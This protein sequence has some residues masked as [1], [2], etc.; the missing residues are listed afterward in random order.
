MV[1]SLF[2]LQEINEQLDELD[3][4]SDDSG[5][6]NDDHVTVDEVREKVASLMEYV[7]RRSALSRS[8]WNVL[9]SLS[10][11]LMVHRP[12]VGEDSELTN[13][14]KL[15]VYA[16]KL[17]LE[18][19][20]ISE[21][22]YLLEGRYGPCQ[23]DR[24]LK[25]MDSV[26]GMILLLQQKL[27]MEMRSMSFESGG[28]VLTSY[29]AV[30][31]EKIAIHSQIAAGNTDTS[32]SEATRQSV[33][34]KVLASE[35][36]SRAQLDSH[37]IHC[38]QKTLGDL[39]SVSSHIITRTLIQGELTYALHNIKQKVAS[40]ET[41]DDSGAYKDFLFKQLVERQRT[42]C[43][44][45]D[46]YRTRMI[47]S[48]AAIISKEGDEV[49]V[50][51]GAESVL[52]EICS[53]ISSVM[54]RHIQIFKQK[55]RSALDTETA[56]KFDMVVNCLRTDRED[57][58]TGLRTEHAKL[59]SE[60]SDVE[61]IDVPLQSLDTTIENFGQIVSQKAIIRAEVAFVEEIC[62][63]DNSE[64]DFD[65]SDTESQS[66]CETD[67]DKHLNIFVKGLSEALLKEA[68]SKKSIASN[69]QGDDC[70]SLK[71]V[72][73][74]PTL[75]YPPH[76][77]HYSSSIVR[78]AVFQAQLTYMMLK[79]KLQ[80]SQELGSGKPS[81]GQGSKPKTSSDNSRDSE[82][83][84]QSALVPLEEVLDTMYDDECEVLHILDKKLTQL[85]SALRE[86]SAQ[87]W[88]AIEEQ[89]R[90][91]EETFH[92]EMRVV[93]DRHEVH[94]EVFKQE[95]TKVR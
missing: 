41:A 35:A 10:G 69:I 32:E 65:I 27:E 8:D 68:A 52:E 22:A 5:D 76:M 25:E 45:V 29:T 11:Q 75:D 94:M 73:A 93:S 86:H 62:K 57:I 21:M 14:E 28:S 42:I 58:L 53:E 31:A 12:L 89:V 74:T 60:E 85:K 46:E 83:D 84:F 91:F 37:I 44:V 34:A 63:M 24:V 70:D 43:G 2:R 59:G 6:E 26:N 38:H 77:S 72:L 18:S 40:L 78:E 7:K 17:A 81:Y 87:S 55:V 61:D 3:E 1:H 95:V 33:H 16:D 56:H 30:L 90:H 36:L 82:F 4:E 13:D 15:K 51:A 9:S 47:K 50:F 64:A 71:L 39:E 92:N 54:E 48:L 23:E 20:I 80:H 79:L 49:A 19:V 88:P 66:D 67:P